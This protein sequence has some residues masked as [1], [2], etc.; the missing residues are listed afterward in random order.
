MKKAL[1]ITVFVLIAVGMAGCMNAGGNGDEK[2]DMN[3]TSTNDAVLGTE[4]WC[5]E[6][7]TVSYPNPQTG[8]NVSWQILG[9]TQMD[10]MTVCKANWTGLHGGDVVFLYDQNRS[11][12][13]WDVYSQNGSKTNSYSSVEGINNEKPATPL[14]ATK[15]KWCEKGEKVSWEP[16][17]SRATGGEATGVAQGTVTIDDRKMC[18][19]GIGG[20]NNESKRYVSQDSK[21]QYTVVR[22]ANGDLLMTYNIT[23]EGSNMTMYREDDVNGDAGS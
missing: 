22:N 1:Y 18:Q 3:Q 13:E 9:K 4:G 20:K 10:S 23:P 8:A 11:F 12:T 14:N 19:I 21:Y 15:G 5:V 7:G 6:G 17:T 2:A 16:T